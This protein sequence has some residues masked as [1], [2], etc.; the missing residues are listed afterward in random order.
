MEQEQ[1]QLIVEE[2]AEIRYTRDNEGY[3]YGKGAA[4]LQLAIK[5]ALIELHESTRNDPKVIAETIHTVL[6]TFSDAQGQNSSIETFMRE[7]GEEGH[8]TYTVSWE[9]GPHDWS[10]QCSFVV[11]NVTGRLC[12]PYYGFDLQLYDVE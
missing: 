7:S 8:K 5:K 3:I 9:S 11:M 2:D 4:D 1:P 10:I 6:K 12:E